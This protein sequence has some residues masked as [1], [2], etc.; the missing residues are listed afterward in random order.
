[1]KK[2]RLIY[3]SLSGFC[4]PSLDSDALVRRH[5][6]DSCYIETSREEEPSL[7]LHLLIVSVCFS[8]EQN[9]TEAAQA[10]QPPSPDG[11]L[12]TILTQ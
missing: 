6:D 8:S 12:L 1:M 10:F 9:I 3:P 4:L 2:Y 11:D 5:L 7:V